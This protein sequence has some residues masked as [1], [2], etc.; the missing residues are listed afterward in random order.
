[1]DS[2]LYF[3]CAS[4]AVDHSKDQTAV[5][6]TDDRN[7]LPNY[8]NDDEVHLLLAT[9]DVSTTVESITIAS[10]RSIAARKSSIAIENYSSA[11]SIANRKD[12]GCYQVS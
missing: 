6:T 5:A 4:V 11:S 9:T 1:M 7:W 8:S 3:P 12:A 10:R 2:S